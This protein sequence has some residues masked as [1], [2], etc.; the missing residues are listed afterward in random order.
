MLLPGWDM[1]SAVRELGGW[2]GG[3]QRLNRAEASVHQTWKKLKPFR[4]QIFSS[5]FPPIEKIDAA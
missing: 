1:H 4:Q 2:Q 5:K 3:K